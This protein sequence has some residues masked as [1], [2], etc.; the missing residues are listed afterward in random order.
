M[1][2]KGSS[3]PPPD[4]SQLADASEESARIMADL[5]Y[6]QLDEARRQYERTLPLI[7]R[8]TESQIATMDETQQQGRDY[9]DYQSE[10]YRPLEKELVGD[11]RNFSTQAEFERRA[12]QAAADYEKQQTQARQANARQMASMG[13]NP[14][15]GK[16]QAI[17]AQSG[18]TNA[19]NKAG[20]MNNART[21]AENLGYARRMDA[22]G[23]GRNL[24]GASQGAYGVAT[25]AGNSAASN[26]QQPGQNLMAGMGQ[27]SA[28][29]G[30]G[31]DMMQTGLGT[32]LSG[33]A[34]MYNAAQKRGSDSSAA[35]GSAIGMAGAMMM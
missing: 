18:L 17:Q 31:R 10:T 6:Q 16:Y 20:A 1:G 2:G 35:L 29:I 22:A 15:S 5:G 26:T 28:T 32:A 25:S 19:A 3:P 27:G 34:D 12:G 33:Q 8:V 13:V 7:E 9:Y 23:L 4:Y 24:A 30:S 21:Q 14:N 11:A